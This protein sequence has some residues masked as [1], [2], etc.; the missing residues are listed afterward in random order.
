MARAGREEGKLGRSKASQ[1]C[2][3]SRHVWTGSSA[4][5]GSQKLPLHSDREF[6][7]AIQGFTMATKASIPVSRAH[8]SPLAA[9]SADYDLELE[10]LIEYDQGQ[11]KLRLLRA[12]RTDDGVHPL[13]GG[14][15]SLRFSR[16]VA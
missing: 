12:T 1:G 7:T 8:R 10:K 2:R 16:V 11:P 4:F 6:A 13:G 9:I 5:R 3:S 14:P 15:L